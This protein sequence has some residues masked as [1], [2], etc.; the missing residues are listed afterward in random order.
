MG[1]KRDTYKYE[2][3]DGNKIVHKGITNDLQR[4]EE[5]H[6]QKWPKG[7][8]KQVGHAVTEESGREWEEEQ[9]VS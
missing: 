4:R 5:E 7:H 3:K 6:Q 8:I 1:S 9:G 2:F